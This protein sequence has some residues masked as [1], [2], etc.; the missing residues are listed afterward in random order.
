MVDR[1]ALMNGLFLLGNQTEVQGEII[2]NHLVAQSGE[3]GT[4]TILNIILGPVN[5]DLS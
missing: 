1:P 2:I 3:K 5:H 4:R